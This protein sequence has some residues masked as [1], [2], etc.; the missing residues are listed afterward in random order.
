MTTGERIRYLRK[1]VL[2]LSGKEF[3]EKFMVSDSA[4]TMVERGKREATDRLIKDICREFRVNET[5]LRTGQGD[6]Y[7]PI[8][9]YDYIADLTAKVMKERPESFKNRFIA[10]LNNLT[11]DEWEILEEKVE[12]LLQQKNTEE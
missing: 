1:E 9:Q 6:M 10:M 5:W 3:G 2:K 8:S 11:E 4:I 12:E 7:I